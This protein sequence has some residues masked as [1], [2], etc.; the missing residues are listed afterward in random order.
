MKTGRMG[1]MPSCLSIQSLECGYL[2]VGLI[3]T[4]L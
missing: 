3:L 1:Q 2:S 4:C